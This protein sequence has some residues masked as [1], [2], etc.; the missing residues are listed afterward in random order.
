MECP[1]SK[2]V[3]FQIET[4]LHHVLQYYIFPICGYDSILQQKICQCSSS[5]RHMHLLSLVVIYRFLVIMLNFTWTVGKTVAWCMIC[6]ILP[7][8]PRNKGK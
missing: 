1:S 3:Y 5:F 7:Q 4:L 2:V 8:V 6:Q